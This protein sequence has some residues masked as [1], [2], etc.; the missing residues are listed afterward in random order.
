MTTD[1]TGDI[2]KVIEYYLLETSL[3][4]TI[5]I[6]TLIGGQT[7][8]HV[9]PDQAD[10]LID[11]AT[12]P[13]KTCILLRDLSQIDT[14]DT[15]GYSTHKQ[16]KVDWQIE[17]NCISSTGPPI[18]LAALV[19]ALLRAG[20]VVAYDGYNYVIHCDSISRLPQYD[21]DANFYREILTARG[22]WWFQS[23]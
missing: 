17:I 21:G 16:A 8:C 11:A 15:I 22:H 9:G 5:D 18:Q 12:N 1:R 10:P 2:I 4:P 3:H 7:R 13:T 20:A 19:K 23:A 14:I 6:Y